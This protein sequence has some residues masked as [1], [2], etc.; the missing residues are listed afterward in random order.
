MIQKLL[1]K[2][3]YRRL[4]MELFM[5]EIIN[6]KVVTKLKKTKGHKVLIEGN[7]CHRCGHEWRPRNLEERPAVCPS[8]KSPYWHRKKTLYRK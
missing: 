2:S 1:Y 4:I 8:C 6:E 7:R 5:N 3:I